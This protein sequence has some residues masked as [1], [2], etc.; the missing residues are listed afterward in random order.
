MQNSGV[1]SIVIALVYDPSTVIAVQ[2]IVKW[3]SQR[4]NKK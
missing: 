2:F 1:Q 3:F 4:Q